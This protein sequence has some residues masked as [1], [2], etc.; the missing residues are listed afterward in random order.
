MALKLF[1]KMYEAY[2]TRVE[3]DNEAYIRIQETDDH[4]G[5][6][7]VLGELEVPSNEFT[8]LLSKEVWRELMAL[9]NRV[10]VK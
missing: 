10:E 5:I 1:T 7:L 3:C 8:V 6:E 4:Q 2:T 9:G